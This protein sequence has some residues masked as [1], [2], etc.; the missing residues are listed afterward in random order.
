M[1]RK[2]P[3]KLEQKTLTFRSWGGARAGAGRPKSAGRGRVAH[4]TRVRLKS[5]EPQHTTLRLS[6][7]VANVRRWR[8]F[9]EIVPAIARAQ[10]EGFRVIEFSVQDGHLHLITEAS[11]WKALSDGVRALEIR[12]ARAINRV[13][14]RKGR[15]FAD[16]YHARGLGSPRETRNAIVYVL[17]N[18]RKHLAQ[19]GTTVARG[20]L[21]VFSS[22][23]FFDGWNA[24][25]RASV[26]A[27]VRSWHA[28]GVGG[29]TPTVRAKSWLLTTG[30]RRLG[31]VGTIE[32]PAS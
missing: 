9:A 11:G 1:T 28:E 5:Y 4:R 21:D 17:Q 12:L 22:A 10:R 18:A 2:A 27:V 31:L 30:W 19:R 29:L 14:R 25:A 32:I 7:D 16:R 24:A 23:A 26:E 20:W 3:S 6:S 13:L 15:V 8:V